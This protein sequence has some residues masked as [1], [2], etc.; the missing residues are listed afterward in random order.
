[1]NSTSSVDLS[2]NIEPSNA[3]MNF[4]IKQ[5][6]RELIASKSAEVGR[7]IITKSIRNM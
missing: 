1:M 7:M 4:I 6:K 3:I 2:L 5:L